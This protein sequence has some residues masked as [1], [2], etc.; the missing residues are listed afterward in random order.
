MS[1]LKQSVHL[2]PGVSQDIKMDICPHEDVAVTM[3]QYGLWP[4]TPCSPQTAFS[5][6]LLELCV[7]LQLH[8]SLSVQAFANSIQELD[9]L[10]GMK[11]AAKTKPDLYRNLLGAINEYRYHRTQVTREGRL[12]DVDVHSCGVCHKVI[13]IVAY[14]LGPLFYYC[15]YQVIR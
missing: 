9:L 8:G 6:Q 11:T 7:C 15:D 10:M 5:L 13:L 1:L 2:H 3:L 12:A 14:I 4:A